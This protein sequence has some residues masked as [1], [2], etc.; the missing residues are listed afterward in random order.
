M[1]Y[2]PRFYART[3]MTLR[4]GGD[5]TYLYVK[6]PAPLVYVFI[7]II[8]LVDACGR[9]ATA[10]WCASVDVV[11][12]NSISP[13]TQASALHS[14]GWEGIEDIEDPADRMRA[15]AEVCHSHGAK[16]PMWSGDAG[17]VNERN[18]HDSP[19]EEHRPFRDIRAEARREAELLCREDYR[20]EQLDTRIVNRIGQTAREY[21]NGTEGMW[22]ALRRIQAD[23]NASKE[24][25]IVLRMYGKAGQTLG[26]G[27]VPADLLDTE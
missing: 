20:E 22:A 21:A 26:A 9:D 3:W 23:P 15:L 14:C 11:D 5:G 19:G 7:E 24:Q 17:V 13:E 2:T 4:D 12:L 8:D 1:A 18:R 16:S 10:R 27:P 25:R 6:S